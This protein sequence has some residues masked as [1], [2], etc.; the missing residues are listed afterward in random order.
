MGFGTHLY[1][2]MKNLTTPLEGKL[3][4]RELMVNEA[5][6]RFGEVQVISAGTSVEH[7]EMNPSKTQPAKN[8]NNGYLLK[9]KLLHNDINKNLSI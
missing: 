1:E 7:F 9:S 4:K 6:V 3:Q 5:I 8:F 2:N